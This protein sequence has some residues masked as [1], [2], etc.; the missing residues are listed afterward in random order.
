MVVSDGVAVKPLPMG[1]EIVIVYGPVPPLTVYEAG[2]IGVPTIAEIV[3]GPLMTNAGIVELIVKVIL[4]VAL[5]L[6]VTVIVYV[7]LW[8]AT[9]VPERS[10]FAADA[11]EVNPLTMGVEIVIVYGPAPPLAV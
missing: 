2:V 7:S 11:V 10:M 6:S 1:V 4:A 8:A 9:A 5:V 3:E